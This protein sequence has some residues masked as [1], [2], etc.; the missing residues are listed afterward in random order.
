MIFLA[1]H[2]LDSYMALTSDTC[3][4]SSEPSFHLINLL[5][6]SNSSLGLHIRSLNGEF[7]HNVWIKTS[8]GQ[9]VLWKR[10]LI[11]FS[12]PKM[13][14]TKSEVMLHH[15]APFFNSISSFLSYPIKS[16]RR[17]YICLIIR[18]ARFFD[19]N[20]LEKRK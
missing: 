11:S 18:I 16:C 5:Q 6:L 14:P 10:F 20:S 17:K 13:C 12:L 8:S 19:L 1:N 15:C 4:G 7:Q 9:Y 3:I 2:R